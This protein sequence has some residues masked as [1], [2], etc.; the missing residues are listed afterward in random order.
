VAEINSQG[1]FAKQYQVLVNPD[2]LRH[3]NV[4]VAEVYQAV[5]RNNANAGGGVLP[6]YA[7][8]FLIRGVGLVKSEDDLRSIVIRES[9]AT[10]VYLRDVAEVKIGPGRDGALIKNGVTESVGGIALMMA[11]GNA[12]AIV[13]KIKARV[14]QINSKGMLPDDLQ[15]VPYYDRSELVDAAIHTVVKVL[16]EGIVL[17]VIVLFL[18]LGDALLGDCGG[19]IGADA[20]ADLHL[21]ELSGHF[22]QSHV[23]GRAGHCHRPDGRRFGGGGG[24]RLPP[25]G[26]RAQ[27]GESKV[28]IILRAVVEVATPV[29]FGVGIIILVFLP[30][31]TL[32]GMEGKM[33]AP[34]AYT[35]A[36][37]LAISL[38][39]SLTLTPVLS[40]YL[41]KA[42]GPWRWPWW[43]RRGPRH[44]RHQG[45]EEIL[46]ADAALGAGH[47][48][49]T[50]T[51]AVGGFL[52]TLAILPFLARP[53]FPK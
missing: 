39:L 18:F 45:D 19:H 5:A 37:A 1:G 21:H 29:I 41:L 10:P 36:I 2:Q 38:V 8:Q 4:S 44:P 26:P 3:Y 17:V 24:K 49:R 13:T 23:A 53:S 32:Q 27:Y 50:I 20:A 15:I 52:A 51:L 30:L 42:P 16:M 14:E 11:G 25:A 31:M 48:K 40:S 28:R 7:E 33:F 12:K 47:E 6:Q 43:R 46:P 9:A 34:L 22:G 35:I